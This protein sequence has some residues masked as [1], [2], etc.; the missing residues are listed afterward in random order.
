MSDL[1]TQE[2]C[3]R[4]IIPLPGDATPH[5]YTVDKDTAV[6]DKVSS[7]WQEV[8]CSRT[9]MVLSERGK[10]LIHTTYSGKTNVKI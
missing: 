9:H 4:E 2:H 7:R 3:F 5:N 1:K 8:P 6:A 10:L